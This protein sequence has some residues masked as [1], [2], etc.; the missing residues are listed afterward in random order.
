VFVGDDGGDGDG[1]GDVDGGD[2]SMMRSPLENTPA[3]CI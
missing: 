2:G 1:D 3:M